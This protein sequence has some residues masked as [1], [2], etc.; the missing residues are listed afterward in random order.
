MAQIDKIHNNLPRHLH[1][2]YNTNWKALVET[3]GQADEET[4]QLM[5]DVIKQMFIKTASRPHIDNLGA[6]VGVERPKLIGM[7]DDDFKK[8]IPL[9]SFHPKQI[10]LIFDKLL[11]IFFFKELTTSNIM[12]SRYEPFSLKNEWDLSYKIDGINEEKIIFYYSDFSDITNISANEIVSAINRKSQFCFAIPVYDSISKRTFIRIFSKTVGSKGSV[13]ITGGLANIDLQFEGYNHSSGLGNDTEWLVTKNGDEMFFKYV[14][15]TSPDIENIEKGDMVLIDVDGNK[16]SFVIENVNTSEQ[17]FSFRN[18]FGTATVLTQ[19]DYNQIQFLKKYTSKIFLQDRKAVTWVVD[20]SS[21]V[22]ETPSSP[23][24][25]RRKLIGSAHLNG[26]SSLTISNTSTTITLGNA[27]S[28]PNSGSFLLVSQT[29]IENNYG[30]GAT[31]SISAIN[32]NGRLNGFGHTYKYTEKT[33]NTLIGITPNL[34]ESFYTSSLSVETI[35]RNQPNLTITTIENHNLKVGEYI[36][37]EGVTGFAQ[38]I[39]KSVQI[40]EIVNEKTIKAYMLGSSGTGLDGYIKIE[41]LG[42]SSN[43]EVIS[44]TA[45]TDT[46]ILGST[47]W[48]P[49]SQYVISSLNTKLKQEIKQGQTFPILITD[50]NDIPNGIGY[51]VFDFGRNNEEGPVKLTYKPNSNSIAIDNSYV[52]KYAHDI[53]SNITYLRK[54][55]GHEVSTNGQEYPF[56]IT[57]PTAALVVL[58]EIFESVKSA[59]FFLDFLTRYPSQYYAAFDVFDREE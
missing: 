52:F 56:Y 29:R 8:Y 26:L 45:Q 27:D 32:Q 3:I 58:K 53:D 48:D 20:P 51:V 50:T 18:L 17:L 54:Q 9:L 36:K 46:G 28:F 2:K 7:E 23:A 33:G 49:N 14:G 10:K 16:G 42:L 44:K 21:I 30:T 43:S 37:I 40:V 25:V 47:L 39:N 57:D 55:G 59:G 5:I 13:E 6:N 35:V 4:V 34:P 15:G 41:R 24:V 22:V 19:T 38:E 12:T 31:L 11:D 1:T